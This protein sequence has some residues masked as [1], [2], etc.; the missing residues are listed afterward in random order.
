MSGFELEDM[1][2]LKDK[3]GE[4]E[5]IGLTD[6]WIRK[7]KRADFVKSQLSKSWEKGVKWFMERKIG[8]NG[9]SFRQYL[10]WNSK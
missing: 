5:D 4:W 7:R 10:T 2:N 3:G 8:P 6:L 1:E 9:S